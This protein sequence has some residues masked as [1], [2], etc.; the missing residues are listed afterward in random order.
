MLFLAV[1]HCFSCVFHVACEVELAGA[2]PLRGA[3]SLESF[4]ITQPRRPNAA[5]NGFAAWML[6]SR[7]RDS[8]GSVDP[9][10]FLESQPR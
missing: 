3:P 2:S 6:P 9:V 1:K 8:P 7:R 10:A 5:A 4:E